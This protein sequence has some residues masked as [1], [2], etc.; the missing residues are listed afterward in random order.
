M[1]GG[2]PCC[3]VRPDRRQADRYEPVT[4]RASLVRLSIPVG[5]MSNRIRFWSCSVLAVLSVVF[6][7]ICAGAYLTTVVPLWVRDAPDKSLTFWYSIFLLLGIA[8][9]RLSVLLWRFARD[10]S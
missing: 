4:G 8:A 10:R 2:S 5:Q 6:G 1:S 9:I 3:A 7:V